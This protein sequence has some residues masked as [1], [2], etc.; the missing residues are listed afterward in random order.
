MEYRARFPARRGE[1]SIKIG[2]RHFRDIAIISGVYPLRSLSQI[3]P[4]SGIYSSRGGHQMDGACPVRVKPRQA[5]RSPDR[6]AEFIDISGRNFG[7]PQILLALVIAW[8]PPAFATLRMIPTSTLRMGGSGRKRRLLG[9]EHGARIHRVG[10]G[11]I[12]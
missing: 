1:L 10:E 4:S 9:E 6:A 3:P 7:E 2:E 5:G 8:V 11:R 12:Y